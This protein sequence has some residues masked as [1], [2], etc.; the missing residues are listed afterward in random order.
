[1]RISLMNSGSYTHFVSWRFYYLALVLLTLGASGCY[2]CKG[3]IC[4][5]ADNRTEL[6]RFR[7]I[8]STCHGSVDCLTKTTPLRRGYTKN[9]II[10]L[11]HQQ[12]VPELRKLRD[13]G[14]FGESYEALPKDNPYYLS[15][16]CWMW[17]T[18]L[19]NPSYQSKLM[20]PEE[21]NHSRLPIFNDPNGL[22]M[23]FYESQYSAV[24]DP[25]VVIGKD[26]SNFRIGSLANSSL[27]EKEDGDRIGFIL[28]THN[29][30]VYRV[31]S[32]TEI[33]L[34]VLNNQWII[35]SARNLDEFHQH[36]IFMQRSF[37]AFS[38]ALSSTTNTS[39]DI[40]PLS[41]VW[42]ILMSKEFSDFAMR[43]PS[44]YKFIRT[45]VD[46]CLIMAG[47]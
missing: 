25:R 47:R 28:S 24:I 21:A 13:S 30:Y 1:M 26:Y 6:D 46:N 8:I 35:D 3:M 4:I 33:S 41:A 9:E 32:R 34:K 39:M 36:G 44:T 23:F 11:S 12:L 22:T 45:D 29:S 27:P 38:N 15:G 42:K 2:S 20:T 16:T 17:V 7:D 10:M 31:S 43:T 40:T 37:S 14:Y 19:Q 18:T 5:G